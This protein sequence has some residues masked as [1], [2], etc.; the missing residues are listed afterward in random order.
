MAEEYRNDKSGIFI[1]LTFNEEKLEY[2][3]EKCKRERKTNDENEIATLAVRECL[4]RIRKKTKKSLKHWLITELG[5]TGTERIHMHGIIWGENAT[6]LIK[7]KWQNG[8]I[9]IGKWVNEATINYITKYLTKPDFDH[10]EFQGKVLCSAGIGK[11]YMNRK[12]SENNRYNGEETKETYKLR[13]GSE[14]NLPLYYRN[15]IYS[16]EEREKLWIQKIEKNE[17]CVS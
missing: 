4:E 2:Y 17:I 8:F 11:N 5:H 16:E 7:E 1:T 3:R 13:N 14:L 15:K 10:K 6:E 12:D 9:Y